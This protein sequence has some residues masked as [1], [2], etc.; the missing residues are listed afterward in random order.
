MSFWLPLTLLFF[1]GRE[2]YRET[3][4]ERGDIQETIDFT[5]HEKS[6]KRKQYSTCKRT[7]GIILPTGIVKEGEEKKEKERKKRK[8]RGRGGRG[9]GGEGGRG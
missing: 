5:Q 6:S 9:G 2:R 1:G 7:I 4:I 3:D 8:V